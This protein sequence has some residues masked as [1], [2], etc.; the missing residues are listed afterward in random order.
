VHYTGYEDRSHDEIVLSEN[1]RMV[2]LRDGPS[3]AG[4]ER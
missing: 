4:V 3:L 2:N 1:L